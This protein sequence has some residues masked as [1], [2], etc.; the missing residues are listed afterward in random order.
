MFYFQR[1]ALFI[2]FRSD[3][4][5]FATLYAVGGG[6]CVDPVA[7]PSDDDVE[8]ARLSCA[9]TSA[10]A[11]RC[12][13]VGQRRGFG[14]ERDRRAVHAHG[15]WRYLARRVARQLS[16]WAGHVRVRRNQARGAGHCLQWDRH[17]KVRRKELDEMARRFAVRGRPAGLEVSRQRR[18]HMG[19]RRE[20]Y[21]RVARREA[22]WERYAAVVERYYAA[23]H[24]HRG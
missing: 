19:K 8:H 14:A 9:C 20:V 13:G 23:E 12:M 6:I 22:A 5:H 3:R 21:R 1:V 4:G 7:P 17:S 11:G 15:H 10:R 24:C 18:I 16:L 2:D